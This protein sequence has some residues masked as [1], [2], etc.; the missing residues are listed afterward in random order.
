MSATITLGIDLGTTNSAIAINHNSKYEIIKNSDQMEYTPSVFWYNKGWSLQVWKKAYEQLFVMSNDENVANYKAE[1]KRLMW[2]S[3][4]I[5]FPRAKTSMN[6][7]EVSA[8]ILKYLKESVTKKY[9]ELYTGW[10]VVTVPAYFDTI[11]KEAT[12]RAWDIAGFEYTV[13]LQEPIAAAVAYWFDNKT[14]ENWLV[15]DLGGG[16]FDVAIISSQDWV[17][18][19]KW[20]GWDN[21]LW[22]KDFDDAIIKHII[23]PELKSKYVF[24]DLDRWNSKYVPFYNRLKYLAECSK[25]ELTDSATTQIVVEGIV[26]ESGKDVYLEIPFSRSQFES[27]IEKLVDTSISICKNALRESGFS[28][29]DISRVILVG[30][31]TQSPYIRKRLE[32]DLKIKVDSSVDPLTVVAKGACIFWG[33]QIIPE[34]AKKVQKE[35]K[36]GCIDMQLNYETMTSEEDMM[37]TG[38]LLWENSDQEYYIQIQSEDGQYSGNKIK[39]KNGKFFDTVLVWVGKTNTYFIYL[40]DASGNII[41]THPEMFNITHGISIAGTPLSHSVWVALN[42]KVFMGD[43]AEES[44]DVVFPRGSI[45]PLKRTLTYRTTRSLKKW[46]T[47]NALPIKIYEWESDKADRNTQI[48]GVTVTGAEIPYNL[49]EGTE[50]NLTIEINASNEVQISVYFPSIDLYK[51]WNSM[52]TVWDQEKYTTETMQAELDKETKR[53]ENLDGHITAERKQEIKEEIDGLNSQ[54]TWSDSDTQRKT[55]QKI[56]E[57]KNKIDALEENTKWDRTA[58][59]YNTELE[60]AQINYP[61]SEHPVEFKKVQSLKQD[62]DAALQAGNID[63]LKSITEELSSMNSSSVFNSL[64]GLQAII[65]YFYNERNQSIDPPKSAQIFEKAGWYIQS[66]N[67][68]WL[69]QCIRELRDLMPSNVQK[70]LG[71]ISGISK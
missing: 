24:S 60:Q 22:G 2:T 71:N 59:E 1:V 21:Y 45:L 63:K 9:P 16:T 38:S 44:I 64:E 43:Q 3:E 69:R 20:H 47:E 28:H 51:A 61:L 41:P 8:E 12:K 7:E 27:T 30:W 35:Q 31:S 49:P 32:E 23:E 33:S 17:L 11:Q 52:R 65:A 6:A 68:D 42:K 56:K 66:N 70:N 54:A 55:H 48:C 10:V 13:L 34:T 62:W 40:S 4:I 57:V 53:I 14:N 25:K 36:I 18:T 67:L 58:Q 37:V 15:Y 50:V 19:I 39:L 29:S 5:N 26:D 46:D